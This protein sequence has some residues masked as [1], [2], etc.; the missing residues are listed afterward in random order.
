MQEL[1]VFAICLFP[2]PMPNKPTWLSTP[3]PLPSK[4]EE[5][6]P[7]QVNEVP[8]TSPQKTT[9]HSITSLPWFGLSRQR[10]HAT[11]SSNRV[12][13]PLQPSA[14]RLT[15]TISSEINK[16]LLD[17]LL[18]FHAWAAA[19]PAHEHEKTAELLEKEINFIIEKEKVQGRCSLPPRSC[20]GTRHVVQTIP[21][22]LFVP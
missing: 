18:E 17:I 7:C 16:A 19:K 13:E 2:K 15:V 10:G 5:N 12:H 8:P 22:R 4:I 9:S 20:V 14:T 11:S 21:P 1:V 3:L 6:R